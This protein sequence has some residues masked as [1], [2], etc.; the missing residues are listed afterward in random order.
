M[1]KE[2]DHLTIY[3]NEPVQSIPLESKDIFIE[4]INSGEAPSIALKTI[5]DKYELKRLDHSI[6]LALLTAA[7]PNADLMDEGLKSRIIDA[8]YPNVKNDFTDQEFDEIIER[9]KNGSDSW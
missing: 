3:Y 7:Y 2:K 5:V 4:L 9:I 6:T 1:G 8:D